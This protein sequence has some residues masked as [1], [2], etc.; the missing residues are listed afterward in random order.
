VIYEY[1]NALAGIAVSPDGNHLFIS[2]N[3]AGTITETNMDGSNARI[4]TSGLVTPRNII[5]DNTGQMYV[6]SYPA[7]VYAIA[8]NGNATPA[9]NDASFQGWEIAK[10]TAGNFYLADHFSNV[11]RMIDNKGNTSVIAGSGVAADIDGVG[12]EAAFNGPQGLT[13]DSHGNL[14]VTTFNYDT[15]GGNKVRK[16]SFE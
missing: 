15:N 14:Y 16:I 12:L 2:N 1:S 3:V 11:I 6:A 4:F 7:S 8:T 5:F 9:A 13:I 10:D